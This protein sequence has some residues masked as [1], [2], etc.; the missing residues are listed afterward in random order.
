MV[1]MGRDQVQEIADDDDA[2][3]SK[4]MAARMLLDSLDDDAEV[5]RRVTTEVM[6]RTTGKSQQHIN[7]QGD[8]VQPTLVQVI[9]GK[10]PRAESV[11]LA[12]QVPAKRLADAS[13]KPTLDE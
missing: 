9:S 5:R 4:R 11:E 8:G 6:D 12:P 1:D 10:A 13:N 3:I 2:S 7:V